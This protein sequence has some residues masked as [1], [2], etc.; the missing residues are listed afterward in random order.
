MLKSK[1]QAAL[2]EGMTLLESVQLLEQ[3]K[4]DLERHIREMQDEQEKRV[5]Q[6]ISY[7]LSCG[8]VRLS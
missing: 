8:M 6:Y 7:L 1:L 5:G 4:S 3:Q 2:Q